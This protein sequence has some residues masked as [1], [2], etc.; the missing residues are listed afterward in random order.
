MHCQGVDNLFHVQF[1]LP[2]ALALGSHL[3]FDMCTKQ[4]IPLLYPFSRRPF[5]LP[6]N[7]KLRLSANDFRSE[8]IV[9]LVFCCLNVFSYPLMAQGF[10]ARYNRGFSTFE[11]LSR[12]IKRKPGDYGLELIRPEVI[13]FL[14]HWSSRKRGKLSCTGKVSFC[15]STRRKRS[16][17]TFYVRI[18]DTP[19]SIER[20]TC[21]RFQRIA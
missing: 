21:C 5:V 18:S 15:D 17:L 3:I 9:F 6:A 20:L 13:P 4:G 7:P 10:W 8:A 2:I 19:I 14:L 11:H 1:T 16:C 12:E